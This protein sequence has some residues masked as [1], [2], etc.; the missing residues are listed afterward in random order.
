MY[1]YVLLRLSGAFA[2]ATVGAAG[3]LA[4]GAFMNLLR[5]SERWGVS[6]AAVLQALPVVLLQQLFF[7]LPLA[8]AAA[9]TLVFSEMA[10]WN[11]LA[12]V[13]SA[14]LD[15]RRLLLPFV[16]LGLALSLLSAA[17]GEVGWGWGMDKVA[18]MFLADAAGAVE[19]GFRAGEPVSPDGRG[20]YWM[21]AVGTEKER[22]VFLG[23]AGNDVRDA[24][25][26]RLLDFRWDAAA[27]AL[28]L[29]LADVEGYRK[30]I[31]CLR[32]EKMRLSVGFERPESLLPQ[33]RDPFSRSLLRN[34]AALKQLSAADAG[35]LRTLAA[36][37]T[38][39]GLVLAP[40]PLLVAGAA[41]G[42][43]VRF[44]GRAAA[45]AWS[46]LLVLL[47]YYPVWMATRGLVQAGRVWACRLP[48]ALDALI[49]CVGVL[50]YCRWLEGRG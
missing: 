30:D 27:G 5:F 50:L 45:F 15:A 3:I 37:H 20:R 12:A 10:Q 49:L 33:G 25:A 41:F 14:G 6:T 28:L 42:V 11:E 23:F 36:A 34:L 39:L 44:G 26:G 24:L 29:D 47:V 8:A 21:A 16:P 17:A 9:S 40:L 13:E 22:A 46:L 18:G 7:A 43:R 32:I 48:Y 19:R 4:A 31:G 1:L 38:G 2:A 35:A